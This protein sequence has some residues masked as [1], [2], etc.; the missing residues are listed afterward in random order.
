VNL[1]LR[2]GQFIDR[3]RVRIKRIRHG[4]LIIAVVCLLAFPSTTGQRVPRPHS[5]DIDFEATDLQKGPFRG[6]TLKGKTV[7][8]QTHNSPVRKK[9]HDAQPRFVTQGF[10]QRFG[11]VRD[12]LIQRV[13][14]V[15][16]QNSLRQSI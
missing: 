3:S 12:V 11:S 6:L 13:K 14:D 9:G 2:W 4:L 10:E 15:L 1:S 5:L 7:L 8:W 16:K